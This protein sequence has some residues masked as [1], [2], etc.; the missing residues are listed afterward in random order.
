M[1]LARQRERDFKA[2]VVVGTWS[3]PLAR[4]WKEVDDLPFQA[5]PTGLS[6]FLVQPATVVM[7]TGGR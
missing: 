2:L 4:R 7:V 3:A 6:L 1:A 5:A